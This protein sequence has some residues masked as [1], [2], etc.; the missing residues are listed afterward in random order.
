MNKNDQYVNKKTLKEA[1][2]MWSNFILV[3]KICGALTCAV[4]IVMAITLV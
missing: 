4:L 3:S 1:E 2:D